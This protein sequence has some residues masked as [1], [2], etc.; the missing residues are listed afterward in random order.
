MNN[1]KY[2]TQ[3]VSNNKNVLF[4]YIQDLN[5]KI[6]EGKSILEV[7]QYARN[8]CSGLPTTEEI[9][10]LENE[11]NIKD[12]GF[13]GKILEWALFG[14][15]PNSDKSPDLN[16]LDIDI[17]SCVFKDTK[18]GKNA[19]ER[20]TI[21]NCGNTNNYNTF[22]NIIENENFKNSNFYKKCRQCI[23]IIRYD[24]KKKFKTFIELLNQKLSFIIYFDIEKLPI[25][26]I[27]TI[28][29]DYKSIR[30]CILKKNVS[31]KGQKYLHIHPHGAGHG[32][33]NRAFGYTSKFI[34]QVV[35]YYLSKI[36]NKNIDNIL[37]IT[38]RSI[39]INNDYI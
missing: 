19:K 33:G 12:K 14:Q 8:I 17:K 9:K 29:E 28:N 22:Q 21:T 5:S 37:N 31:Q 10:K 32:S 39:T 3:K 30:E 13:T 15:K 4:N 24:D 27:D 6:K 25:E 20:Q 7:I 18:K 35:G 34:T 36:Y 38:G 2:S 26:M 23:L 16:E 1:F 11:K